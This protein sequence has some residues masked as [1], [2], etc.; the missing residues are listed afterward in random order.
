MSLSGYIRP[1][2][3]AAVTRWRQTPTAKRFPKRQFG[4]GFERQRQQNRRRAFSQHAGAVGRFD[5]RCRFCERSRTGRAVSR[6][7]DS[8][9]AVLQ[10][11]LCLR[12][13]RAQP[14]RDVV[15]WPERSLVGTRRRHAIRRVY[16][17]VF[18]GFDRTNARRRS[19]FV[20][21]ARFRHCKRRPAAATAKSRCS[22]PTVTRASTIRSRSIPSKRRIYSDNG[23]A[24]ISGAIIPSTGQGALGGNFVR[25]LNL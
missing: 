15:G 10:R 19:R 18:F 16:L 22:K 24:P 25:Q 7:E 11:R 6:N 9:E 14:R 4:S 17:L 5:D 3:T 2:L 23:G 21:R 20:S 13:G 8:N 12:A 1:A